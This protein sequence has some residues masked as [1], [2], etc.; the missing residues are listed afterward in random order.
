M[1]H[2]LSVAGLM[3]NLMADL[4]ANLMADLDPVGEPEQCIALRHSSDPN[5]CLEEVSVSSP[6]VSGDAVRHSSDPNLCLE[7]VSVSSPTVSG[8]AFLS[9]MAARWAAHGNAPSWRLVSG[10]RKQC[11]VFNRKLTDHGTAHEREWHVLQ[12]KTGTGK[13]EGTI[14]YASLLA[15][16][17]PTPGMLIVTRL[18]ADADVIASEINCLAGREVAVASHSKAGV[19]V[20]TLSSFPVVVITHS[21]YTDALERTGAGFERTWG[22]F[23]N[24]GSGERR[25]LIV[26]DEA[27]DIIEIT[28][29]T[30]A[31]VS[32]LLGYAWP[33]RHDHPEAVAALDGFRTIFSQMVALERTDGATRPES[34]VL[35]DE[36]AEWVALFEAPDLGPLRRHMKGTRYAGSARGHTQFEANAFLRDSIDKTFGRVQALMRQF[37]VYAKAGKHHTLNTARLIVPDDS[38]GCVVLD[39]T[40]GSNPLYAAMDTVTIHAP[41]QH[42]RSYRNVTLHVARA[43]AT[44]KGHMVEHGKRLCAAL[45]TN[46]AET[47]GADRKVLVGCHKANEVHLAGH[48]V[49]FELSLG[50]WGA[51]DG[52]NQWRDCDTAVAFGLPYR[53]SMDA[54]V[55][56]FALQG[57][58]PTAWLHDAAMREFGGHRDIRQAIELGFV[59]TAVVQ[60][61][62]R[63]RCRKVV[64]IEG[65]C[66][67]AD[68]RV[69]LPR[70]ERG[71]A[72][73]DSIVEQMPGIRVKA[74]AFDLDAALGATKVR[75]SRHEESL[76][77]FIRNQAPGSR[78][79]ATDV[80][81][82]CGISRGTWIRLVSSLAD[83]A[84]A[85]GLLMQECGVEYV[86]EREGKAQRAY[87]IHS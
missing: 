64:D 43:G 22:L 71:D 53:D 62:N 61:L 77:V 49:P 56:F 46:L 29:L 14:V 48:D 87:L 44:G 24:L 82:E 67:T 50:H 9:S 39:A 72:M 51:I 85:L 83:P 17:D 68:L 20:K 27:I 32:Q 42:T 55:S 59:V 74:W 30:E 80:Q 34:V 16:I 13:T 37:V 21:A 31:D 58:Q 19:A 7:E 8:D 79:S 52:S 69:V 84:S 36:K 28:R 41:P 1:D 38:Q 15:G 4:M 54:A 78:W 47:L 2:V 23:A 73:L 63:V 45:L 5:L 11:E 70:G 12:A 10:W 57:T 26:I 6:T 25:R 66:E 65:N 81:R 86:V 75:R 33:H 76:A 35:S 40:A 3:A 60:F 18:I